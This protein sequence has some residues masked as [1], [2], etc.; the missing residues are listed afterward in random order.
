MIETILVR[1]LP[2]E[3]TGTYDARNVHNVVRNLFYEDGPNRTRF[4]S[5][6]EFVFSGIMKVVALFFGSSFRKTSDKY[7]QDF[8]KFAE[9]E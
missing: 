2:D 7:M 5:E 1:N 8:K 6:N 9:S 3:F 4:V